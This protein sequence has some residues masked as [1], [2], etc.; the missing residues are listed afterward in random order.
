MPP[1]EIVCIT[2]FLRYRDCP[3]LI[4]LS[5][6]S[7]FKPPVTF[8]YPSSS[9]SDSSSLSDKLVSLSVFSVF[10]VLHKRHTRDTQETQINLFFSNLARSSSPGF[11]RSPGGCRFR[12]TRRPSSPHWTRSDRHRTQTVHR[13]AGPRTRGYRAAETA[14]APRRPVRRNPR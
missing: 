11:V 5:D 10:S 4:G 1:R 8:R 6:E 13:A 12:G 2:V 9:G 7:K 3:V 14:S